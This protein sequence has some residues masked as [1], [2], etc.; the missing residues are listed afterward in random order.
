[1]MMVAVEA[2]VVLFDMVMRMMMMISYIY[3]HR[4]GRPNLASV[5]TRIAE[6]AVAKGETAVAVLVCGPR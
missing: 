3:Q 4:C 1:M 5:F 2:I 6:R